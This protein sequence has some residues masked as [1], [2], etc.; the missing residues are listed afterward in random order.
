MEI[1]ERPGYFTFKLVSTR[2]EIT[3]KCTYSYRNRLLS[4]NK[5]ASWKWIQEDLLKQLKN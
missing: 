2:E 5:I 3:V 4:Q 1:S